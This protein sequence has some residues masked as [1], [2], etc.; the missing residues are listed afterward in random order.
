MLSSNKNKQGFDQKHAQL[1]VISNVVDQKQVDLEAI[2]N[3]SDQKHVDLEAM[4]KVFIKNI[5][6]P[7]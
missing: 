3:A 6:I 7:K 5:L 4:S 2:S 1:E